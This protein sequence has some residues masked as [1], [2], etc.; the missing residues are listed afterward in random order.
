MDSHENARTTPHG[1][2]L[3]VQRLGEG[4]SVG[5]VA[6]AMG[7]TTKD[8]CKWRDRFT[9]EGVQGLRDRSARP[10]C[11]PRRLAPETTAQIEALRR[12]RR[13]GPAIAH[14]L[15]LAGS[16]VGLVLRRLG[17]NRVKAL[18]PKPGRV[19]TAPC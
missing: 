19:P 17:L 13:S 2:M 14:E 1:R 16:T 6:T 4:Q 5:A 10:L 15:G 18:D 8:G 12:Q 9:A 3:I 7:L 11:S